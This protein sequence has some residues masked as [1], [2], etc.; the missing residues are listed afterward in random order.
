MA[1]KPALITAER[2]RAIAREAAG[3]TIPEERWDAPMREAY[4]T[5]LSA[6]ISALAE[7]GVDQVVD[8]HGRHQCPFLYKEACRLGR[9][10]PASSGSVLCPPLTCFFGREGKGA[11]L[12]RAKAP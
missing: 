3:L 8:V 10:E 9:P 6:A 1:E 7:L 2:L 12:V 5:A 4:D 11:V